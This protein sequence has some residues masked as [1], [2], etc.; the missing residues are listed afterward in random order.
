MTTF[1]KKRLLSPNAIYAL[2]LLVA[3]GSIS[4]LASVPPVSRDALTHHLY[5]PKL[6]IQHGGIYELHDIICSYYPMNL[7]L[8]YLIPLFFK[9]DVIPKYIHFAFALATGFLIYRYI[10][11]RINRTFALLGSLFFLTIPVIVRLSSTVYVD[12]GLIFFL[13]VSQLCIFRWIEAGFK[14][15]YLI[16]GAVFCGLALGTKYNGLIGLFLLGLFIPIIYSR[17]HTAHEHLC[18]KSLSY[19]A[20]F[21][22]I[23]L[24]FFSPWMIRNFI[25]TNNPIY[26]LY[27]SV[28]NTSTTQTDEENDKT[29]IGVKPRMSRFELRRQIY[30]E[31]WLEIALVPVRVFFEGQDDNPARFDGK[32]NPF[33]LLLPLFAIF[34]FKKRGKQIKT[35]IM[36]MICFSILYFLFASAQSHIRIRYI[37]P[38]LP[39]CV[40]LAMFGL[41]N[42]RNMLQ[43]K[44]R[45][46]SMCIGK[47]IFISIIAI[48]LGLNAQYLVSRFKIDQPVEYLLGKIGRDEY[49]QEYRPEYD[50]FR[51][52]NRHLTK[53]SK[54]LGLYLGNRGYYLDVDIIFDLE[55]MQRFAKTST[56]SADVLRKLQNDNFSH[57]II[58]FTS[59]NYWVT[60]YEMHERKIL[61]E[62]F[63]EYVV[64]EFSKDGFG[65]LKLVNNT[66]PS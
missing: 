10:N 38:I 46:F 27:Q 48:M 40:I 39:S 24:V 6:Y 25:W 66:N 20:V 21:I 26:P 29:E 4:L 7:D 34:R 64:T 36:L 47:G 54:I 33:L 37:A 60:K 30:G 8:L 55:I 17:Y 58:N 61:K 31:S 43:E 62:F 41:E 3:F 44:K 5:V 59:F 57:L 1:W 19:G 53:D 42:L 13:F 2:G 22:L 15:K 63:S 23:A 65:L 12:L 35:E 18:S 32:T 50:T 56:S 51:Y 52:A 16:L 45:K 28:F 9:N 14:V 49:I 11:H